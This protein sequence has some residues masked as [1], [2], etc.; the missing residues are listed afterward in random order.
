M[1][2][3]VANIIK[4]GYLDN[5]N[6]MD[7]LDDVFLHFLKIRCYAVMTPQTDPTGNS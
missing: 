1:Q 5:G 6:T 7:Y 2:N 4:R 3:T